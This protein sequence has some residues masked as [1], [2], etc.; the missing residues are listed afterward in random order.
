[1]N[2]QFTE[3][4]KQNSKNLAVWAFLWLTTMALAVFGP[5]LIWDYNPTVSLLLIIINTI[6]GAGM[7]W[8]NI[9]YIRGLDEMQRK[10]SLEAMAIALGVG[11]VGGLS[12]SMLEINN[13][14]STDAEISYLVILIGLTYLVGV[15]I[16]NLRYK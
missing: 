16:G 3:T 11:V 4:N 5:K 8:S 6:V 10:L 13:V 14:I 7:I 1:M 15:F 2:D 9:R 12:Y